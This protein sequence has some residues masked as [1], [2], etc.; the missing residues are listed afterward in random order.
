MKVNVKS[1]L[2]KLLSTVTYDQE[3]KKVLNKNDCPSLRLIRRKLMMKNSSFS[4]AFDK[5]RL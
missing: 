3:A 5:L 4:A 2:M 1:E